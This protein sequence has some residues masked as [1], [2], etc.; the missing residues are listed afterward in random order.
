MTSEHAEIIALQALSWLVGNDDLAP[1]FMGA[2]GATVDDLRNGA[3][4]PVTLASVLEFLLMDDAW[5]VGF[6]DFAELPYD[7]VYQARNALPG[8]GQVHWT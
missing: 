4:N 7:S 6:C 3:G 8:A 2:T 5:I 1:I